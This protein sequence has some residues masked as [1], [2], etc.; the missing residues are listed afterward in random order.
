LAVSQVQKSATLHLRWSTNET[1]LTLRCDIKMTGWQ[2]DKVLAA[3][4]F[5]LIGI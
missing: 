1:D 5:S 2:C 3:R 4:E